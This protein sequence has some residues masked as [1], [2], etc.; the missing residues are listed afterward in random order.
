MLFCQVSTNWSD[1]SSSITQFVSQFYVE[2]GVVELTLYSEQLLLTSDLQSVFR[3]G[4]DPHGELFYLDVV[5]VSAIEVKSWNGKLP[6]EFSSLILNFI[7]SN[8]VFYMD[9]KSPEQYNCTQDLISDSY[10]NS[11]FADI[12]SIQ[13]SYQAV[14]SKTPICPFLFTN[15]NMTLLR[16][17]GVMHSFLVSNVWR[18]ENVTT[19]KKSINSKILELEIV[20]YNVN[21][22][23]SFIP[24]LVF[25]KIETFTI[26]LDASAIQTGLFKSFK[27]VS[28]VQVQILSMTNF[29]HKIGIDWTT[30]MPNSS[31]VEF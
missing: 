5:D 7:R 29:F 22:D 8:I 16:L 6:S 23:E 19:E 31:N 24:F 18:W 30:H 20:S 13:I 21:L 15:A 11:I 12:P 25:E 9:G 14:Y 28:T 1:A 3:T 27:K 10:I 17:D 2:D 4:F 26:L